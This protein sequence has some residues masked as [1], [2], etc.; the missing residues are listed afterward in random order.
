MSIKRLVLGIV[1]GLG[2][3]AN[4]GYSEPKAKRKGT[5]TVEAQTEEKSPLWRV[6]AEDIEVKEI[7]KLVPGIPAIKQEILS[8]DKKKKAGTKA[9]EI[10]IKELKKGTEVKIKE[11]KPIKSF[12]WLP[13]SKKIA[14]IAENDLWVTDL[15]GKKTRIAKLNDSSFIWLSPNGKDVVYNTL[16]K[17]G[18]K[19]E[20]CDLEKEKKWVLTEGNAWRLYWLS[21]GKK[22]VVV[23]MDLSIFLIN[24]DGSEKVDINSNYDDVLSPD[25]KKI[26]YVDY[27]ELWVMDADGTNKR[28][29]TLWGKNPSWS[30]DG[31]KIAYDTNFEFHEYDPERDP[32]GEIWII[33]VDGTGKKQLTY[34]LSGE[35]E[36]WKCFPIW[37]DNET[38]FYKDEI[39]EDGIIKLKKR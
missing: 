27:P 2:L 36:A 21:G 23:S 6:G 22:I 5:A 17:K 3:I 4:L 20:Y 15:S 25:G 1:L 39:D 31:K 38:I 26:A 16:D 11:E 14:Y 13:N 34:T 29:L 33:N 32:Q 19:V 37:L 10:V 18:M 30:P 12:F 9:N 8:P 7:I 24:K 28:M 35:D